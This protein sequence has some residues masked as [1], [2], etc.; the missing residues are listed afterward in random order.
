MRYTEISALLGP[1]QC[2]RPLLMGADP[3]IL[4]V[5][6]YFSFVRRAHRIPVPRR[7]LVEAD[8]CERLPFAV[9]GPQRETARAL[10]P[11]IGGRGP[12]RT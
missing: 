2:V 9:L 7:S 5:K 1:A 12:G 4:M 8:P 11:A 6:T 3:L 10:L